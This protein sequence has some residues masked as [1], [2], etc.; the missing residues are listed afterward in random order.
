MNLPYSQNNLD[1]MKLNL[2]HLLC[3]R[4]SI[5]PYSVI[6]NTI[7]FGK[8][9]IFSIARIIFFLCQMNSINFTLY[10]VNVIYI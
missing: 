3:F 9:I 6:I 8:F 7:D 1:F 2:A 4:L 10:F 5:I